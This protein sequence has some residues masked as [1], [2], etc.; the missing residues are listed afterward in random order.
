MSIS[1]ETDGEPMKYGVATGMP[2]CIVILGTLAPREWTGRGQQVDLSLYESGL[3]L[4]AKVA[5][6]HLVSGREA[7]RFANGHPT[8]RAA[9][10]LRLYSA[11]SPRKMRLTSGD[12][13]SS[14]DGPV[15]MVRPDSRM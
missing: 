2:V 14:A 13:S 3:T 9:P 6:N 10:D 7:G 1:G 8:H 5:A 4:R 15:R 12:S 11:M